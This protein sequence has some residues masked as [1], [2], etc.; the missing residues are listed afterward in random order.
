M[1]IIIVI[2]EVDLIFLI[3]CIIWDFDV[4]FVQF[5]CVY[6]DFEFYVQWV[7][8]NDVIIVFDVW[9]VCIGGSWCMCNIC[10]G[11]EY[12]FYG[13]FY[14]VIEDC[15]VQI[16]IWDVMLENVFFEMFWFEDFGNGCI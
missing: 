10:G 8:F 4:I 5:M 12:S 2:I 16:F 15:I 7:G 14:D 13:F 6:F 9:E 3:I 11:E 1:I